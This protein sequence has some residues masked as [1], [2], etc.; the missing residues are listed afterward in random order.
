MSIRIILV[1]DHNIIRTGLRS[2]LEK[3]PGFEVIAE[4]SD[5]REAIERTKELVPDIVIMDI[6]MAGLNGVEATRQ[7]TSEMPQVKVL[8]LSMHSDKRYVITM[9]KAGASGYLLKNCAFKE[10]TNA[11]NTVKN[12]QIYLSPTIS[13]VVVEELVNEPSRSS[14]H[15]RTELTGRE[16]EVLQ[17]LAE[18]NS[19]KQIAIQ[20]HVSIST[21]ETHRRQIME[22]L[23]LHSIAE[24]TKYAIKE[25]ITSLEI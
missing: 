7:I 19:T 2:L 17:L 24:L 1:D 14:S 11:I 13:N 25:G 20:L 5:G 22:K 9:L 8:A 16:R 18:G 6:G 15:P 3:Q 23:G 12:N 10:M 21:V 4:A